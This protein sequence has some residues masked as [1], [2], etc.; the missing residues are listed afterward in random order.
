MP[1]VP[2]PL[3]TPVA[4]KGDGADLGLTVEA[5]AVPGKVA[6]YLE[7]ASA[8]ADFGTQEG[9]TIGLKVT[10]PATGDVASSTFPGC[11]TIDDD[12]APRVCSGAP[13]GPLRRHALHRR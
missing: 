6:L 11:A 5:F 3:D 10:D 13:A 12:A 2:L 7:D 4:I 8:G 9:D 1:R